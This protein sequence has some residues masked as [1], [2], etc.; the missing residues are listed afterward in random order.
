MKSCRKL[1]QE[2]LA[3]IPVPPETRR[4]AQ[5]RMAEALS[6]E[7]LPSPV[8]GNFR[9]HTPRS[10][11]RWVRIVGVAAVTLAVLA[12]TVAVASSSGRPYRLH[13]LGVLKS[14]LPDQ[15]KPLIGASKTTLQAA[16]IGANFIVPEPYSPIANPNDLSAVWLTKSTRQVALVFGGGRLSI[17][18]APALYR[19]PRQAFSRFVTEN[20]AAASIQSVR[21]HPVLVIQP[22]TDQR[23]TNP[24]WVELDW[25]GVDVNIF[26]H[27]YS[28]ANL[29]RVA[30]SLT[31]P[32]VA[33]CSVS[34]L[35]VSYFGNA[36]ATGTGL[37]GVDIA[38]TSS[39]PCWLEGIPRV[40]FFE[41]N[42][43]TLQTTCGYC[44]RYFPAVK[45][46][47]LAPAASVPS[48]LGIRYPLTSA[49][50]VIA[51][52]DFPTGLSGTCQGGVSMTVQLPGIGRTYRLPGTQHFCDLPAPVGISPVMNRQTL[53]SYLVT[54]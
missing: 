51:N 41:R 1:L 13:S 49:G 23:R 36:A 17:E 34:Q 12:I 39:V 50:F 9:S 3:Q 28:T 10:L 8:T 46:V 54:S 42:G 7:G 19:R 29:L 14:T 22:R 5:E 40:Q 43:S 31:S 33:E 47:V 38:N 45:R 4:R 25:H 20:A 53:F 16:Q 52:R 35:L 6:A 15:Q 30:A 21:G 27:V 2:D 11:G 32:P 24:S 44:H 18:M 37:I 26:S 48:A